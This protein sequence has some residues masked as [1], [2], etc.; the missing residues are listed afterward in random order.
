MV[1]NL[2]PRVCLEISS[3]RGGNRGTLVGG[4][5][6]ALSG[7]LLG[8]EEIVADRGFGSLLSGVEIVVALGSPPKQ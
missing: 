4:M 5:L 2:Q 1:P 6:E 8:G 3:G 7:L